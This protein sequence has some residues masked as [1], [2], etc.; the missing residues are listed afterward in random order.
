[1][2]GLR[3]RMVDRCRRLAPLPVLALALAGCSGDPTASTPEK[4]FEDGF[5]TPLAEVVIEAEGGTV[6]RGYNAWLKILPRNDLMPRREAEYERVDCSEARAFFGRVLRTDELSPEHAGL[7]CLAAT[8]PRFDFDNGRWLV[9]DRSD[10]RYYYRVWK[11][12]KD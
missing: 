9:Y 4:V 12:Y 2:S 3:S 5:E 7:D 11:L 8:D 10:G 1:M 6:V